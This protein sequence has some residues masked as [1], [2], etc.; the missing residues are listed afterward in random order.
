M[1]SASAAGMLDF[2]KMADH[3]DRLLPFLVPVS[4]AQFAHLPELAPGSRVLDLA[5][6]TGEPGLSL[7]RRYPG[8]L[9]LGIDATVGMIDVARR[10]ATRDSLVNVGFD[11]MSMENL[12]LAADS[13]DAVISRFGFLQFVDDAAVATVREMARVLKPFGHYNFALWERLSSNLVAHTV[14]LVLRDRLAAEVLQVFAR[15]DAVAAGHREALLDGA[16]I[17]SVNSE[18]FSWDYRFPDFA[19]IWDI[20]T[21]P[22]AFQQMFALLSEEHRQDARRH[23]EELLS[24]YR[25]HDGSY[26]LPHACRLIWGHR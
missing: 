13:Q 3:F 25:G 18:M 17:R 21:G 19:S 23:M 9:L 12:A 4:D 24:R 8:V 2:A 5:C 15:I 10:K 6:G 22:A 1:N 11:V 20:V 7:S 16:G 26:I 14:S